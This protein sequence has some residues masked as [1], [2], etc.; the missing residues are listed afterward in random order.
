MRTRARFMLRVGE[1]RRVGNIGLKLTRINAIHLP[2]S[3]DLEILGTSFAGVYPRQPIYGS[4]FGLTDA[5]NVEIVNLYTSSMGADFDVIY[6]DGTGTGTGNG[7]QPP[8]ADSG[9][10][11]IYLAGAAAALLLLKGRK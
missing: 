11:L 7:T 8:Q 9:K 1:T 4:R 5:Y 10:G 3:A 2:A 6:D